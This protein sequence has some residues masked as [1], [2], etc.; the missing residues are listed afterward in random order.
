MNCCLEAELPIC[1]MTVNVVSNE[2]HWRWLLEPVCDETG[3]RLRTNNELTLSPLTDE[4]VNAIV[5]VVNCW[6][7]AN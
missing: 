2:I 4:A 7:N 1:E 5:A 3:T 6:Y